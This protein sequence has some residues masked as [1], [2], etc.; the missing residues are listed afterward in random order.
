[1]LGVDGIELDEP[2]DVD[3]AEDDRSV[4]EVVAPEDLGLTVADYL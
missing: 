3:M 4:V 2:L 1:M